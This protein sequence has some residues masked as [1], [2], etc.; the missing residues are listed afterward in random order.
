[1]RAEVESVSGWTGIQYRFR[2]SGRDGSISFRE[3][4]Y[5]VSIVVLCEATDS[6]QAAVALSSCP[7]A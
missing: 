2:E 5:V 4:S 6:E 1:M 3:S 7:S